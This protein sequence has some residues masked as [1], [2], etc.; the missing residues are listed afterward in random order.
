[1]DGPAGFIGLGI[2][3]RP[4]AANLSKRFDVI[5]FDVDEKRFEGLSNVRRAASIAEVA[6]SCS[7]VLLSLPGTAIVESVIAGPGGLF[8]TLQSGSLILDLST[9]MP[10]ASQRLAKVAVG[11]S[12]EYADAPV[13][14]G[15]AGATEATLSVMVGAS[16]S[17]FNRAL[18]YLSAIG[19]SVVRLGEVGTGGV[20]KLVNNMI[21]GAEFAVIAEGFALAARFGLDATSL[22]EAIR[23]GWAA[24]K[25]L[26][27]SAPAMIMQ[28]Y[29]P[30]G[31]VDLIE[32]DIGYART[33]A[34]E[35]RVPVPVTAI[36]HEIYVAAQARG[37]GKS[38]Q[39][40]IIQMWE[41]LLDLQVGGEKQI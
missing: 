41:D 27:V 13:S 3:G 5:G 39:P 25:V 16:E 22:F 28:D 7:V 21:V 40:V 33:L 26:E 19:R 35:K 10:T 23:G 24:S 2:M 1:M 11:K 30:G 36:T 32:K 38:A 4:M 15:E 20:A 18:P 29:R 8:E 14:G 31:T 6:R 34:T 17:T 12:L 9:T 37:D